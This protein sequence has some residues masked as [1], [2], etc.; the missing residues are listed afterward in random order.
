[1]SWRSSV[2]S[3]VLVG[4]VSPWIASA[5]TALHL[6]VHTHHADEAHEAERGLATVRHGHEHDRERPDHEHALSLD[7]PLSLKAR[8]P[9][10]VTP[11]LGPAVAIAS[12]AAAASGQ[13]RSGATGPWHDPPGPLRSVFVL[14][15]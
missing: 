9:F 5:A 10:A 13:L 2:A 12:A 8:T 1:M 7:S 6:E 15:I 4:V 11:A 3:L 14:R